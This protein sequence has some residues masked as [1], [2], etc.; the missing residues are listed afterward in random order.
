MM[1][2]A[3]HGQP[4]RDRDKHEVCRSP[5]RNALPQSPRQLK[6]TFKYNVI[7]RFVMPQ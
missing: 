1:H 4:N 7:A 2:R 6:S 3:L 5:V